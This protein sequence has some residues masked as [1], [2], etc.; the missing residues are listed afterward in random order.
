MKK[1]RKIFKTALSHIFRNPYHAIAVVLVMTQTFLVIG[2]LSYVLAGANRIIDYFESRAQISAYF[3]KEINSEEQVKDLK[4]SLVATGKISSIRFISK[5]EA[6][7]IFKKQENKPE[8]TD[9]IT[10][11][12]LPASFDINTKD[13]K[14]L[15]DVEQVLKNDSRVKD[16]NLL[17]E[18]VENLT[19]I[20]TILRNTGIVGAGILLATSLL[21][22]LIVIGLNI[23]LHKDEIEIMRLV[24][25]NSMY[26]RLPFMVEGILYGLVSGFIAWVLSLGLMIYATPF[27]SSFF[28]GIPLLPIP[29]W[30]MAAVLGVQLTLGIVLGLIGAS[31]ATS[32][33][34]KV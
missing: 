18:A 9:F 21:I 33:Y 20:A 24:G 27:I 31:A 22:V 1:T 25:A 2:I 6:L 4:E 3:G 19:K 13:P 11:D 15:F 32:K 30:F 5:E 17:R 14:Y 7:D 8:L 23:S 34:L 16:I 26:V 28:E 29:I 12:T 10:S